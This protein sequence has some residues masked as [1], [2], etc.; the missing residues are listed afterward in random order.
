MVCASQ[1]RSLDLGFLSRLIAQLRSNSNFGARSWLDQCDSVSQ[2][3]CI[4]L[5]GEVSLLFICCRSCIPARLQIWRIS[6]AQSLR[7]PS[8][9]I[10][11]FLIFVQ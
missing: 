7:C 3:H 9:N 11:L 10:E 6:A 4:G 1:K 8:L 5:K 2:M